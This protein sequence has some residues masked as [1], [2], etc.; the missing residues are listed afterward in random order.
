M[1]DVAAQREFPLTNLGCG[2]CQYNLDSAD[3]FEW[4][5]QDPSTGVITGDCRKCLSDGSIGP[6]NA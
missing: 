6:I 1:K 2:T 3:V 5:E 4:C